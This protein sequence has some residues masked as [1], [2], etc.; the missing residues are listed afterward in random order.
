MAKSG[1]RGGGVVE[2]VEEGWG[3]RLCSTFWEGCF[4]K[5]WVEEKCIIYEVL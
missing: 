3:G 4:R 1:R 2:E 5:G